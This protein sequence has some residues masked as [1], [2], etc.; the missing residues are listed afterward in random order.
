MFLIISHL[1]KQL[2]CKSANISLPFEKETPEIFYILRLKK[3]V[4]SNS[5]N[6]AVI[7]KATRRMSSITWF[8]M[9]VNVLWIIE[10][11]FFLNYTKRSIASEYYY[12][13]HAIIYCL[14]LFCRSSIRSFVTKYRSSQVYFNSNESFALVILVALNNTKSTHNIINR[15]I[16]S[17]ITW[18]FLM[19][20]RT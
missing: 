10:Y 16:N 1:D 20:C 8:G 3:T 11:S 4:E 13:W 5:W 2:L 17:E 14:T 7:I 6:V 9:I 18:D 15:Y 19:R 12:F